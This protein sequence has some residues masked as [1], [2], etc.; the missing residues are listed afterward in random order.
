MIGRV[1]LTERL[2]ADTGT[3]YTVGLLTLIVRRMRNVDS[4]P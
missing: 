3:T 2:S 4:F 1:H